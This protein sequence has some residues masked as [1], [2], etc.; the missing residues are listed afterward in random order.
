MASLPGS[1]DR[2]NPISG[3]DNPAYQISAD[4]WNR[5]LVVNSTAPDGALFVRDRSQPDG[6]GLVTDLP[7]GVGVPASRMVNGHPLSADVWVTQGDVGLG[8][9]E[10][11]ALSTWGG[12][13]AIATVG[14]ITS[15]VWRGSVIQGPYGGT[16]SPF[17]QFNGP[18]AVHTYTVPD[19]DAFLFSTAAPIPIASGGTG[20]VTGLTQLDASNLTMGV[21]PDVRLSGNVAR[22]DLSANIPWDAINK[23]HSSLSQLE[24]RSASD[25]NSGTLDPARLPPG[26]VGDTGGLIDLANDVTGRLPFANLEQAGELTV[27]GTGEMPGDI[28]RLTLGSGLTAVGTIVVVDD[29]PWNSINKAG[30]SLADLE[31]RSASDLNT[32]TIDPARLPP[33]GG[34]LPH[35]SSHQRGGSDVITITQLAGFSGDTTVYLRGDGTFALPPGGSGGGS[36]EEVFV[37]PSDPGAGFDL[38]F[39]TDAALNPVLVVGD[40]FGPVASVVDA[41]PVFQNTTGK[42]VKDSGYTIADVEAAAVVLARA[43]ILPGGVLDLST[44]PSHHSAHEPGGPDVLQLTSEARLFG[45]GVGS[46][47]GPMQQIDLG[48]GMSMVGTTLRATSDMVGPA[49]AI[50]NDLALFSGTTG[51]L[52]KDSGLL[53]ANV[54]RR[55][56]ANTFAVDQTVTGNVIMNATRPQ[57]SVSHAGSVARGRFTQIDPTSVFVTY[58]V[59]HDGTNWNL[60]DTAKPASIALH[61]QAALSWWTAT[62]GANPR[63]PTQLMNLDGNGLTLNIGTLRYPQLVDLVD[64]ASITPDASKGYF[65]RLIANGDRTLQPPTNPTPGQRIMIA[66]NANGAAR[67]LTLAAG[68]RFGSD[69]SG[70]TQTASGKWDYITCVYNPSVWEV[71]GVTKGF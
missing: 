16:G 17:V 45:R 39:D 11:V 44:L 46:G 49:V 70:L 56:Q 34:L 43:S 36:V 62:A 53:L 28:R 13:P 23:A 41:I 7:P 33:S 42:L 37:G 8:K 3:P 21:V 30:S 19:T 51:K 65:F 9:V 48:P 71:V 69:F 27:L 68:F 57:V 40:M 55:D 2:R 26:L 10:N 63:T 54:A 15:G 58:N 31:V 20:V 35:A 66:H 12:S 5:A 60:D 59:S 22:R 50:D 64:A 1:I 38:W 61:G 18:S 29:V 24:I 52:L 25:L 32:G 14:T 67:T 6:W 4:E 47:A